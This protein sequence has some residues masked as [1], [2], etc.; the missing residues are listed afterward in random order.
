MVRSEL[1]YARRW[2]AL[3]L[4]AMVL[5]FGLIFAKLFKLH[6]LDPREPGYEAP[7]YETKFTLPG[8]RGRHVQHRHDWQHDDQRYHAVRHVGRQV[9]S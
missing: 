3:I 2:M 4:S 1:Q 5:F 8:L 7:D 9:V 6:I